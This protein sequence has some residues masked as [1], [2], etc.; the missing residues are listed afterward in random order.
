MTKKI[1]SLL[2]IGIIFIFSSYSIGQAERLMIANFDRCEKPNLI[3]GDFGGWNKTE[4]DRSQFCTISFDRS[5]NVYGDKGCSLQLDYDVDSSNS[6]YNGFW[7]R[8]EKIDL[9]QYDKFIFHVKGDPDFGYTTKMKVE[10]KSIAGDWARFSIEGITDKWQR[11]VLPL[12][13]IKLD[14]DFSQG[15][16]FTIV[17]E[18]I[19]AT[20]KEGR[21]Y[22]DQVYIE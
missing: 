15:Y 10:I 21:I 6:A 7:M 22:I 4:W 18:D 20:Q 16:E 1:F 3:G 13:K 12:D 9:T 17:F 19:V 11:V 14:G 2:F 5:E 8:L